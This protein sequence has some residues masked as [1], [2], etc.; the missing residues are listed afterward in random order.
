[1]STKQSS[2][3][4][5]PCELRL[6]IY[7]YTLTSIT[8]LDMKPAVI[9]TK[10]NKWWQRPF[11]DFQAPGLLLTNRLI[12]DEALQLYHKFLLD[13]LVD[14]QGETHTGHRPARVYDNGAS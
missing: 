6:E 4:T 13:H 11:R 10:T 3:T 1:M 9:P 14:L 12:R 2:I 5:L 7:S 8:S